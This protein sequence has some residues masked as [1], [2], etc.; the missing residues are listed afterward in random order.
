[1]GI[2]NKDILKT[3]LKVP[4]LETQ[5]ED[6]AIHSTNFT[7]NGKIDFVKAFEKITSRGGGK[8]LIPAGNY[9]SIPFIIPTNVVVEGSGIGA[10]TITLE[11][12]SNS[13]FVTLRYPNSGIKNITIDGNK[14]NNTNG[15]CLKI[16]RGTYNGDVERPIDIDVE[17]L[18][19]INAKENGISVLTSGTWIYGLRHISIKRCDGHGIYNESSDNSYYDLQVFGCGKSAICER[20]NNN[21]WIGG[22]LYYNSQLDTT[23]GTIDIL[24]AGRVQFTN[25][26]SQDCYGQ[27]IKISNS[28]HIIFTGCMVDT[29][30]LLSWVNE[31]GLPPYATAIEIINSYEVDLN[32]IVIAHHLSGL[33]KNTITVDKESCYIYFEGSNNDT[34]SIKEDNF[35][36]MNFRYTIDRVKELED[37]IGLGDNEILGVEWKKGRDWYQPI[38]SNSPNF[39]FN[40]SKIYGNIKRCMLRGDGTVNYYLHPTNSSLKADGTNADFTGVDGHV[41]VEIPKFY[42]RIINKDSSY[43]IAISDKEAIGFKIHPW[44]IDTDGITIKDKRYVGAF[45]ATILNNDGKLRSL[46]NATVWNGMPLNTFRECAKNNGAK[47]EQMTINALSAIQMLFLIEHCS[48]NS[49]GL[50]GQGISSQA[51]PVSTGQ[52]LS[53]GNFSG[54]ANGDKNSNS[55]VSY[56][57]IENLWGNRECFVD[58]I[59]CNNREVFLNSKNT[60]FSNGSITGNYVSVGNILPIANGFGSDIGTSS[61]LILPSNTHTLAD[62]KMCDRYEGRADV[63]ICMHG[64]RFDQQSYNGLFK[65]SFVGVTY[66]TSLCGGRLTY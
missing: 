7:T 25:I 22:K 48:F 15:S 14:S 27:G 49:Q 61:H 9:T 1:M 3:V 50:I 32:G 57:G 34:N 43:R 36:L 59:T 10:T 30:G 4:Q 16:Q 5:L 26:E 33:A 40:N 35:N 58:G 51:S 28:G 13:D 8:L 23:V 63:G 38:F 42:F 29:V 24:N 55:S 37:L 2:T 45:E 12:N 60:G 52:T 66:S 46:P 17:N 21:R 6:I 41:M 53:L 47:W 62:K 39:N 19:L 64:G 54:V 18:V 20:G 31:Q 56:R 65:Y 44:F 11:N